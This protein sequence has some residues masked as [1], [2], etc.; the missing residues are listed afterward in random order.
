MKA[1]SVLLLEP[2]QRLAGVKKEWHT[3]KQHGREVCYVA[4]DRMNQWL[5]IT[6]KLPLLAAHINSLADGPADLVSTTALY[7]GADRRETASRVGSLIKGRWSVKT[8]DLERATEV[9]ESAR[10][11]NVQAA[12][13]ASEPACYILV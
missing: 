2:T 8:V 13:V 10:T 11:G 9:F 12:C 5:L 3:R 7:D 6:Q 4:S 1:G